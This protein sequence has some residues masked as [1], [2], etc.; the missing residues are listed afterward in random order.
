MAANG[1]AMKDG[2]YPIGDTEDLSNAIHA[3]GRGGADH[4]TIRA[5]IIRRAKAM[6]Q[7]AKIPDNWNSDGSLTSPGRSASTVTAYT[8]SFAL[9]DISIRADGSGRT[10]DAYATVFNTPSPVHDQDGEYEEII[11]PAAFNRAIEHAKRSRG[12]WNIPVM[13]NHGMTIFHTPSERHSVPVGTPEE[14]RPDQ[15]G[16]F[17]RTRYHKTEPADEVLEAIREG[18]I[19]AYSFSGAFHRSDPM[20]PRGGF[21]ADSAGKLRV[22][23]R[24]E[25]TLREF[26]PAVFPVHAGAQVVGVRAE[27]AALLLGNLAPGEFERLAEM[28]RSGT[29]LGDSPEPGTPPDGGPAADD[30]PTRG[31]STRSPKQELQARRAQFLIRHGGGR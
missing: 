16:L 1:Q 30:P 11:D 17:T 9:E 24:I 12:G 27:Q 2:S 14:I 26:G 31:H 5:H 23:R 8:R 4:D 6:G 15:R 20:I 10:V 7:S 29:P 19:N 3:V 25:S 28:F 18:S 13:F 21:R 22:V